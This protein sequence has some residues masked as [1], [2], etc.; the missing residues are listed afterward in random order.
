MPP[1][2]LGAAVNRSS[3]TH[4]ESTYFL[5]RQDSPS[6]S[7]LLYFCLK[8]MRKLPALGLL[9]PLYVCAES[10]S[11][12]GVWKADLAQ[13]K[14]AGPPGPPPSNYLVGTGKSKVLH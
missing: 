1:L 9:A 3:L 7:S 6:V 14:L 5:E 11:L 8:I 2:V 13:S 12:T 10:F 4:K